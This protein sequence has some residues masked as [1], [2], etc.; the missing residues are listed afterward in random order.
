MSTKHINYF[1]LIDIGGTKLRAGIGDSNGN[2]IEHIEDYTD[3]G[4]EAQGAL[5]KIYRLA[6]KAI[7]L[8]GIDNK[9]LSKIAVSFGGPVDFVK[10]TIIKSQHVKGWE[11]FPLCD[12]LTQK[13]GI[14]AVI[15]NDANIAALGEYVYGAGKGT[16]SMLYLTVSTGVG[17]G[18][19][20]DGKI[21]H[22]KNTLS[23]EIG[24]I[25]VEDGGRT[26]ECGKKGCVEGY[27]SGFAV[28]KIAREFFQRNPK[29]K[30]NIMEL[31][32]QDSEKI[33]AIT[34][35]RAADAGD[36]IAQKMVDDSIRKLAIAIANAIC[37]LDVEKVVIGGGVTHEKEKFFG[38]LQKYVDEFAMFKDPYHVPIVRAMYKDEAGLRGCIALAAN[39]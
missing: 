33:T 6:D 8:S 22:G 34:V 9:N 17:G 3:V 14:P 37:I 27:A 39:D 5:E 16:N 7:K 13:Y 2:I 32:D 1:L 24:H 38:P 20:L 30:S 26:C 31:V 28:G 36:K 18:V 15:D 25:I 35:Y 4:S 19:I 21:W 12:L 11:N 29:T 10:R 23:G